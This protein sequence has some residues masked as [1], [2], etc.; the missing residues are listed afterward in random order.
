MHIIEGMSSHKYLVMMIMAR[1]RSG[2][3]RYARAYANTHSVVW[4]RS[5]SVTQRTYEIS[6]GEE[7]VYGIPSTN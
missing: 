7:R 4:R 3:T 1:R 5:E 2:S 6:G